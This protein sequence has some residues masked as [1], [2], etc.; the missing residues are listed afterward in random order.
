MSFPYRLGPY[1][2]ME[3]NNGLGILLVDCLRNW[4]F[5]FTQRLFGLVK[6]KRATT[7]CIMVW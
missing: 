7:K 2:G 6:L 3:K 1:G 4:A 5:P